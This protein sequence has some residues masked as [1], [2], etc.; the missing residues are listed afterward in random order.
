[1]SNDRGQSWQRW[2]V[3][4][5]LALGIT[6]L[7]AFGAAAIMTIGTAQTPHAYQYPTEDI[8]FTYGGEA[9][10]TAYVWS[11]AE[12]G[13]RLA[14]RLLDGQ[15]IDEKSP[16]IAGVEV[17]S[18]KIVETLRSPPTWANFRLI[19]SNQFWSDR[20]REA[21]RRDAWYLLG[22]G[23]PEGRGYFAGFN[24]VT[25]NRLGS[26]GRKGFQSGAPPRE[27]QFAWGSVVYAKFMS[28]PP[29]PRAARD[30]TLYFLDGDNLVSANL[31]TWD[32]KTLGTFLE[33]KA[34]TTIQVS[35]REIAKK[36]AQLGTRSVVGA[37]GDYRQNL[38]VWSEGQISLVDPTSGKRTDFALP[39]NGWGGDDI[40]IYPLNNEQLAVSSIEELKGS[41]QATLAWLTPRAAD[42]VVPRTTEVKLAGS[43]MNV[44]EQ[45]QRG[46]SAAFPSPLILAVTAVAFGPFSAMDW[47]ADSYAE[48]IQ[49]MVRSLAPEMVVLVVLSAALAWWTYRREQQRDR[50][51]DK[52]IAIAVLL[53]GIP[54]FLA[55]LATRCRAPMGRCAACGAAVPQN[56]AQCAG[57]GAERARPRVT[58]VEVFA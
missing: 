3:F 13:P 54:G 29:D 17:R 34:L 2:I 49:V 24:Q 33:A 19:D 4:G 38:A 48:G 8:E 53:L 42:D 27:D 15:S 31:R 22:E 26:I 5:V 39:A 16:R 9:V 14:P 35:G 1:M 46:I 11:E 52:A 21:P 18:F 40:R 30:D 12:W 51:G 10:I 25:K 7:W 47:G 23:G 45:D 43:R 50:P 41:R 56:R 28:L 37:D 36:I 20:A 55:Y 44:F 6:A 32:V 57:C 58:G